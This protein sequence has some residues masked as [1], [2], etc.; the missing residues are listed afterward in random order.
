MVLARRSIAAWEAV[1]VRAQVRFA[2]LRPPTGHG[3]ERFSEF[4]ADEFAPL[5]AMS[6][7]AARER[8]GTAYSLADRLPG[9]LLALETGTIDY[10]RAAAMAE[11]TDPLTAEQTRRVED[12]VLARGDRCTHAAFRQAVRRAVN[13]ADP[14]GADERRRR[15]KEDRRVEIRPLDDGMAELR[16]TL[17]AELAEAIYDRLTRLARRAAREG[18]PRTL[19]QLRADV[20]AALLLGADDGDGDGGV[21]VEVHVTVPATTLLGLADEPGELEGY[22][23]I[24]CG[25]MDFP[26]V[27]VTPPLLM[28]MS[29]ANLPHERCAPP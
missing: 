24:P 9:T 2:G 4:A 16:L 5:L 1:M 22:G 20:A 10:R 25:I 19:G 6:P 17:P 15:A 14:D 3:D 23:P 11:A 29:A 28:I 7:V 8:L 26:C 12:D 27:T 18:D 13:K 21:Q